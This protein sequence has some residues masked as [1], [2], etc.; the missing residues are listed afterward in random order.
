M[1]RVHL[2][3]IGL[4]AML[5]GCSGIANSPEKLGFG[6]ISFSIPQAEEWQLPNGLKV[7]YYFND[8]LPQ[9]RGRLYLPGGSLFN[10]SGITG[11]AAATGSQMREGGVPG[12]LPDQL[13]KRLD[14]LAASIESAFGDEYGTVSFFSLSEDFDEVFSLFGQVVREP[15]FNAQRLGLW[16]MLAA[17]RIRRRRDKPK[18]M[19]AMAFADLV[20]GDESAYS[21]TTTFESVRFIGVSRISEL[22]LRANLRDSF[23]GELT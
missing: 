11:L 22:Q 21:K 6:D 4:I 15:V 16:K 5:A 18:T 9:M 2:F 1:T 13:D 7:Y 8:E 17:E 10:D 20:Y 14:D 12:L 3:L 19:A 23:S